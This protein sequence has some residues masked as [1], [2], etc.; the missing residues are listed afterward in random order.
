M[1]YGHPFPFDIYAIDAFGN[2]VRVGLSYSETLEF[3]QL[4]AREP[5]DRNG[6]PIPWYAQSETTRRLEDRWF[7]LYRRHEDARFQ[8]ISVQ[9]PHLLL[10]PALAPP[11]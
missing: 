4:D 9:R 7:E 1:T 3:E 6:D 10:S 2:R 11:R 5:L 8:L